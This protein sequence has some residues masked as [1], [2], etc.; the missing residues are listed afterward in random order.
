MVESIRNIELAFGDGQKKITPSEL[1]NKKV[2]RKSI[3]ASK[4]IFKGETFNINNITTKRPESGIS[5]LLWDK[6]IG[7]KANKNYDFDDLIEE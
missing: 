3:V 2:A 1:Q 6:I 4:K 5:P 7:K